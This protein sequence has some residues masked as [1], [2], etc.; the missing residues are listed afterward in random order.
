MLANKLAGFSISER[1]SKL[2]S[3]LATKYV[4]VIN[5]QYQT[6]YAQDI[7]LIWMKHYS[8]LENMQASNRTFV[9]IIL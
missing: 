6:K 2:A 7:R 8:F 4:C 1:A 5:S 3:Y 9:L